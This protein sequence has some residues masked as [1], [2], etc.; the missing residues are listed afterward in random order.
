MK[1]LLLTA[2]I[3]MP[4][5]AFAG[6][7]AG[8]DMSAYRIAPAAPVVVAPVSAVTKP[9]AKKRPT[10]TRTTARR[11]GL[12][13]RRSNY[14]DWIESYRNAKGT[15][16]GINRRTTNYVNYGNQYNLANGFEPIDATDNMFRGF[17]RED[18]RQSAAQRKLARMRSAR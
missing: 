3:A 16:G 6:G 18:E 17:S 13:N 15:D 8:V 14:W 10:V 5:A 9:V 4:T 1:K 2:M 7:G 12:T 11:G